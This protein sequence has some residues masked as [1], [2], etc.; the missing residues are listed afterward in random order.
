MRRDG[1]ACWRRLALVITC[2][3]PLCLFSASATTVQR[4]V[5][6][7][8]IEA[9]LVEEH[10]IPIV[11]LRLAHRG[12][13]ALDPNGKEGL[14]NL[15]SGLL[16]EGAGGYDSQ[17]FQAR[18]DDLTMR[19]GFSAGSDAFF[20]QVETLTDNVDA[21]F[22]MLHLALSRPRF[23][24]AAVDRIRDQILA[25]L[26][27]SSTDPDYIA[28][29]TWYETVF[30]DHP[31]GRPGRGTPA[32]VAA[33][34]IDDLRRFVGE[35][36]ARANLVIGIVG[37]MTAARLA[38][39]LDK[40]FGPLPERAAPIVL[41]EAIPAAVGE[42]VV[43]DQEIPQS[44]V[45]FGHWGPKRADP[46]F[47]D[48]YVMNHILGGGSFTSRLTTEVREKRGL[49]Y[50]I[51]TSLVT[52]DHAGLYRGRV[53]T[54]NARVAETIEIIRAE[55]ARMRDSGANES[56]LADAKTFLTGSFPLRLDSNGKIANLL[57]GI[58]LDDLGIDYLDRRNGFIE[59]VD[60]EDVS[61][62]AAA[63]LKPDE[64][65]FVVVGA[66]EGLTE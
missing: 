10:A 56:E 59:A 36:L 32:S 25:G 19:L 34:G 45:M 21:A 14:A 31:Y 13:A 55:I 3:L 49:A 62:A 15:V 40:T 24:P 8:G 22:E 33:I 7:G 26:A 2:V 29:R 51:F 43:V 11:S 38:P 17:A 35:R 23:E 30:G 6:P 61:Q 4:V 53:A 44:I 5:S 42:V 65:V 47:Y 1:S 48:A 37:D 39:L 20:G 64:L 46:A 18:L 52:Y 12:G 58:Q 16:D 66:P 50:D 28:A 41:E 27:R 63:F 57:V 60:G 9:W 54:Q